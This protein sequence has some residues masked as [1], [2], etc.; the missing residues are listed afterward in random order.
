MDRE[1][2]WLLNDSIK[3][4]PVFVSTGHRPQ[5][6][7]HYQLAAFLCRV[8]AES[9]VKSAS[10]ISI[11]EG[12]IWLYASR[13]SRA[14][15]NIRNTHL[16]WPGRTR[17]AFLSEQMDAF[18]FPGCLGSG[19]GSLFRLLDR[20]VRN[21]FAYWCCKKFY[22][23]SCLLYVRPL[24]YLLSQVGHPSNRRSPCSFHVL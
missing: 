16:S 22:A 14:F 5:R 23:V 1:A 12:S 17:R 20:P 19:D 24:T 10:I 7:V 18:G 9:A 4:D 11:A 8:G 3:D 2:F 15:R 13:V 21:G 6:P